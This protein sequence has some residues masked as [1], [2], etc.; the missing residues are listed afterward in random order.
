MNFSVFDFL[1]FLHENTF[2][3]ISEESQQ[4]NLIE[5]SK[6]KQKIYVFTVSLP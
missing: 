2:C 1:S 6:A 5:A 3:I 4:N